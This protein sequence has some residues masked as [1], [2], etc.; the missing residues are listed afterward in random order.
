MVEEYGHLWVVT[1]A[2]GRMLAGNEPW[3]TWPGDTVDQYVLVPVG[4]AAPE[5]RRGLHD[6]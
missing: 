6:W 3:D 1:E 4:E 2:S 5:P